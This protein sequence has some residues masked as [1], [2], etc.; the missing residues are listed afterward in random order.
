M[1]QSISFV[2]QWADSNKDSANIEGIVAGFILSVLSA[3]PMC[4]DRLIAIQRSF[5]PLDDDGTL[6]MEVGRA[7]VE[8]LLDEV[9]RLRANH[10]DAST[11][12]LSATTEVLESL[13]IH[14]KA[15]GDT[16]KKFVQEYEEPKCPA[17][18]VPTADASAVLSEPASTEPTASATSVAAPVPTALPESKSAKRK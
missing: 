1:K 3:P 7:D 17:P 16:A 11:G 15:V 13:G 4:A 6:R 18:T 9:L 10:T 5:E 8:C 2:K 12:W 14:P